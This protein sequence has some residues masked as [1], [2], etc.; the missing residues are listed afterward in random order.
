MA[1]VSRSSNCS[2]LVYSGRSNWLKQV[3]ADTSR[4]AP[5]YARWIWNRCGP[6]MPWSALNPSS[7]TLVVPVQNWRKRARSSLS[8]PRT[9]S[10]NHWMMGDAAMYPV[11]SVFACRSS[12]SISGRPLMRS[13][14]SR[15]LK[16]EMSSWG[17]S[18]WKPSLNIS[19]CSW[20][21]VV[22]RW[23]DTSCTYSSLFA[24]VTGMLRPSGLRSIT[25]RFPKW[26]SSAEKFRSSTFV[27]SFSSIHFRFL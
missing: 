16:M 12:T 19:I 10:Q 15:S 11:Y 24:S 22:M 14:S 27:M 2:L 17:M 26:S 3:C 13:S 21:A 20:M 5:P 4:S 1:R 25:P 6:E 9:T 18:V 8:K 7:G 23:R